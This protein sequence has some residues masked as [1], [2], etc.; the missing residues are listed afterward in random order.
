MNQYLKN[1]PP[2][3]AVFFQYKI[4]FSH[5]INDYTEER[6]LM[7]NT[8]RVGVLTGINSKKVSFLLSLNDVSHIIT[9][10]SAAFLYVSFCWPTYAAT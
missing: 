1:L 7:A 8:V 4:L 5:I 3:F 10:Y 6:K 9:L 2:D